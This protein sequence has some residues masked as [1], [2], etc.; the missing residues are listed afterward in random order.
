M[1]ALKDRQVILSMEIAQVMSY[2]L[3]LDSYDDRVGMASPGTMLNDTQIQDRVICKVPSAI[4]S[5]QICL[6][7]WIV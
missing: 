6:L 5:L 7:N 2:E 3:H 4:R 1:L